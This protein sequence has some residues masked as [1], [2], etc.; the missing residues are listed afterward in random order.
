MSEGASEPEAEDPDDDPDS[1]RVVFMA[2]PGACAGRLE[3]AQ[4]LVPQWLADMIDFH[5]WPSVPTPGHLPGRARTVCEHVDWEL[6]HADHP[7]LFE[8]RQQVGA[9][10]LSALWEAKAELAETGTPLAFDVQL[11]EI[12]GELAL[13]VYGAGVIGRLDDDQWRSV[14]PLLA[15]CCCSI[16]EPR[17]D[18]ELFGSLLRPARPPAV[19]GKRTIGSSIRPEHWQIGDWMHTWFAYPLYG[20]LRH[21]CAC[22]AHAASAAGAQFVPNLRAT[23]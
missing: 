18:V 17:S 7:E 19:A 8:R 1:G 5:A 9:P 13:A 2:E 4:S 14:A 11:E 21:G 22:T 23:A 20:D 6:V 15:T 10:E 16:H 3:P 12:E